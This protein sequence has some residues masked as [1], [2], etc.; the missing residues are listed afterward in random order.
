MRRLLLIFVFGLTAC[1]QVTYYHRTKGQD[2]FNR[3]SYDCE[4]DAYHH[5][6]DVGAAGNPLIIR[7]AY[8]DCMTRKHGYT[9]TPND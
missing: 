8:H 2:D 4:Q 1:A 9:T 7:D 3:D 5:A 6:S